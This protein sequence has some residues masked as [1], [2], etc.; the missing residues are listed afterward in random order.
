MRNFEPPFSLKRNEQ[1]FLSKCK[2]HAQKY[3]ALKCRVLFVA[4]QIFFEN[5]DAQ[6]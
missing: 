6:S 3:P 2:A 4:C 5:S 1:E